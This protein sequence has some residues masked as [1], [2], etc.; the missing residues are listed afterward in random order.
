MSETTYRVGWVIP[1]QVAGLTHYTEEVTNQDI[2]AVLDE[3]YALLSDVEHPFHLIIDNRNLRHTRLTTL[4]ELAEVL[5]F[6]MLER[7]VV[8][9][10]RTYHGA[11]LPVEQDGYLHLI[12]VR[13]IASALAHL[14]AKD[15]S[16]DWQFLDE[17]F[18]SIW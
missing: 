14:R 3:A 7:I 18:F 5:P 6:P 4:A 13:D 1:Y 12:H 16:L 17:N 2:E 10:P 9:V 11:L 8:V 15:D